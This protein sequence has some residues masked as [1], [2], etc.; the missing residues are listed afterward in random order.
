MG[1]GA[2]MQVQGIDTYKLELCG[3]RTL[4]LHDVLYTPKVRQNQLS[5]VKLLKLGFN[6]NFHNTG[7]DFYLRTQF[8]DYNFF[9]DD[10]IILDIVHL[11]NN[12]NVVSYMTTT[13][14]VDFVVW[15]SRLAIQGKLE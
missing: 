1:N 5:I 8:Y 2:N 15:H 6:F 13:S 11:F 3:G 4:L 14:D 9:M 10:F 12:D 7:C